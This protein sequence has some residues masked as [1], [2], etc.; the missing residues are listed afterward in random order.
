[1][2]KKTFLHINEEILALSHLSILMPS[3]HSVLDHSD[4]TLGNHQQQDSQTYSELFPEIDSAPSN[5][6]FD[7]DLYN[8]IVNADPKYQRIHQKQNQDIHGICYKS[9]N[10]NQQAIFHTFCSKWVHGKCNDTSV[11]EFDILIEED[12]NLP[13]QCIL[14]AIDEMA[15]KFPFGYLSKMELSDIYGLDLPSQLQLLPSYELR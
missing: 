15:S 4:N 11:K 12:D 10:K 8:V 5:S 7:F 6:D 1:M 9:V 3:I 13:W 14:C 2:L